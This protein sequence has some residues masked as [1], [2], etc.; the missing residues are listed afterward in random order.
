MDGGTTSPLVAL[1]LVL[2][3]PLTMLLQVVRVLAQ[4]GGVLVMIGLAEGSAIQGETIVV[5]FQLVG[6]LLQALMFVA[7]CFTGHE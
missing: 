2:V 4:I 6:A 7:L 5:L 1:L 3:E